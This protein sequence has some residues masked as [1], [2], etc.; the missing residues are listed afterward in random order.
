MPHP[1]LTRRA[2]I[3]GAAGT[4]LLI[5]SFGSD[6]FP[7]PRQPAILVI[8][9]VV[10][11]LLGACFIL[12]ALYSQL[13]FGPAIAAIQRAPWP[14]NSSR[15]WFGVFMFVIVLVAMTA[16]LIFHFLAVQTK[17]QSSDSAKPLA[18]VS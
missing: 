10:S 12:L 17:A 11:A 3:T 1:Y 2:R 18:G 8:T 7:Y 14:P 6:L 15:G 9:S 13:R 16:V 4:F 5:V